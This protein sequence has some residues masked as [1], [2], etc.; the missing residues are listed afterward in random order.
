MFIKEKIIDDW[1]GLNSNEQQNENN[2]IDDEFKNLKEGMNIDRNGNGNNGN[3][4]LNSENENNGRLL[5]VNEFDKNFL[6]NQMTINYN[7]LEL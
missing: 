7:D 1:I 2:T 5:M 4:N 3:V 6:Y